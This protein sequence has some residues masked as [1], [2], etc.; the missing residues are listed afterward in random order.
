MH[1]YWQCCEVRRH[2]LSQ[3]KR[4]VIRSVGLKAGHSAFDLLQCSFCIHMI[5]QNGYCFLWLASYWPASG[6][7]LGH[8]IGWPCLI[9]GQS[10]CS[11]LSSD[12]LRQFLHLVISCW[13]TLSLHFR[14]LIGYRHLWNWPIILQQF[15]LCD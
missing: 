11:W 1:F 2:S 12:W 3:L 5:D 9:I 14:H 7:I 10:H 15:V 4:Q 13:Q 8:L 6:I